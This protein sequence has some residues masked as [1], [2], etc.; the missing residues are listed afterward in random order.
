[1]R[2]FRAI[3]FLIICS[4]VTSTVA[5]TKAEL[6]ARRKE[7]QK[8]IASINSILISTQ[9]R[10]KSL[11]E[12]VEDLQ[13]QIKSTEKLIRVYNQEANL[14]TQNIDENTLKIDRLRTDL[15]Q[16]KNDYALM[17]KQ[18]YRSKNKQNRVMFLLS[19]ASFFQAYKR[20]QY[21]K[22]YANYRKQQ[23]EEIQQKTI[24]LQQLNEQLFA[25][26]QNKE[27]IL[28]DNRKAK[29]KLVDKKTNLDQ[30]IKQIKLEEKNY[31]NE[32]ERKQKAIAKI[33]QEIERLI[34]E[35]IA[36]ENAIA[37]SKSSTRFK[38]TPE[39]KALA[40]NFADNKGKLPWPVVSG[41]VST[42]FGKHRHP[43]VKTAMIESNGVRIDTE[44]NSNAR[45]IFEG[46]VSQINKIPGANIA[47]MIRHG[48]YISVYNNLAEVF[49]EPGDKVFRNQDIGRVGINSS[50]GKTTL[51]FQLF[52]NLNKLNPEV[53]IYKM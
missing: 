37:G 2:F 47:V 50:S 38:L 10:E 35:A 3:L 14:I 7:I 44:V 52:K 17:I 5:Q 13:L 20:L 11:L 27:A 26:R 34:K 45:A 4:A 42:R 8:E 40:D 23:G 24:E 30:L 46:T 51:F 41:I 9:E 36:R 32:L 19:S 6:E 25:Q 22:Q 12:E 33:D 49:V 18:S 29:A 43:I 21:M 48:D 15:E 16:L 1:M 53:W 31:Q 39:A 28:A